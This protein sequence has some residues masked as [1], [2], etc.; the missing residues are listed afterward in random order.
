MSLTSKPNIV[1]ELFN[2]KL[3]EVVVISL[4]EETET[5]R[6]LNTIPNENKQI[7]ELHEVP[8]LVLKENLKNALIANR[9]KL[10]IILAHS[11][12]NYLAPY[13]NDEETIISKEELSRFIK[14]NCIRCILLACDSALDSNISGTTS[15]FNS[16]DA[17]ESIVSALDLTEPTYQ[18]F[19]NK[20]SSP[21]I[22][23]TLI[24]DDT[25]I[26]EDDYQVKLTIYPTGFPN[27]NTGNIN[28]D[29]MPS[30]NSSAV[31][32]SSGGGPP[33]ID[34]P[35]KAG[36]IDIFFEKHDNSQVI[37]SVPSPESSPEILPKPTSSPTEQSTNIFTAR[38]LFVFCIIAFIII[39]IIRYN[40]RK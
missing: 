28:S 22:N 31:G 16:K 33:N 2:R 30:G 32:D 39:G 35:Q 12:G 20:L 24:V 36:T 19:L 15:Q 23:M 3:G 38:N 27:L 6:C 17:V 9:N 13:N 37:S 8:P 18:Q 25:I 5:M 11:P 14:D 29:G 26:G 40:K 10:N 7:L 1:S 34:P 4:I 21:H